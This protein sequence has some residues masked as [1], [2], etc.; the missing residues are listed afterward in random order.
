MSSEMVDSL[1]RVLHI[2]LE[3]RI[4]DE[5]LDQKKQRN[6]EHIWKQN[7]K[8]LQNYTVVAAATD[9]EDEDDNVA[10]LL[11]LA[12]QATLVEDNVEKMSGSGLSKQQ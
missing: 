9:L 6:I 12:E 10:E 11:A 8:R 4:G 3:E 7:R 2:V 1:A 5:E